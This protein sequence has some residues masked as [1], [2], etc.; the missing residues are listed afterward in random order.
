MEATALRGETSEVFAT[1]E[2]ELEAIEHLRPVR[3]RVDGA[4]KPV[5]TDL[6]QSADGTLVPGAVTVGLE[7]SG[8]GDGPLVRLERAGRS[9]ALS[10]PTTLPAPRVEGDTATYPEVLPDVDL[11]VRAQVDGF[12]QLLVVKSAQAAKSPE[13]AELRVGVESATLSVREGPAGGVEA[14]DNGAGGVVFSAPT[15]MMWD[16]SGPEQA[17]PAG[18]ET[19]G[20]AAT[21][22]TAGASAEDFPAPTESGKLAP[23]GVDVTAGGGELVL[24]PD[25]EVLA[26]A[27]TVYPVLIDPQW[28]SPKATAWTM[29]SKYWAD[30]PQ[31][32]FND[33]SD[34]G[35]GYC[36]WDYC[37]PHDTKRLFYTIPTS[38]FVGKTIL[39]AEFV[40]RETWAASCDPAK[41]NLWRTRAISSST[42][43]N[44]QYTSDFWIDYV[45]TQD[46]AY[47]RVGCA[48]ADAEFNVKDTVSLAASRSWSQVTFGLKAEDETDPNAWKRFSDDAFL[49]VK[50]NRPPSQIRMSQLTMDPGGTCKTA[51]EPARVRILPK[52]RA[53]D[54]TDP[55]GDSVAVQ[56]QVWWATSADGWKARWTS[57]RS[58]S[59]SSGSDFGITLPSSIPEHHR[60]AFR[61]RSWDGGNW[62]PWSSDNG[63]YLVLDT[64]APKEPQITSLEYP[65]STSEDPDDPWIDGVGR[66]GTFTLAGAGSDVTSY[67]Y[68]INGDPTPAN[69][70]TTTD[71][72]PRSIKVL[73]S[74]AGVNFIT[75]KAYDSAGNASGTDTYHFR[76]KTG[77]P[78]RATW[79]F[80]DPAGATEATGSTPPR[81]ATLYGG[82]ALGAEGAVN[83]ALGL[84]GVDDHVRTPLSVVDTSVGFSVAAWAKPATAPGG[85]AVVVAQ[86]GINVPGFELSYAKSADAWAFTRH[87]TDTAGATTVR[88]VQ[89]GS[90]GVQAGQWTHLVGTY[91]ATA[92]E[93]RLFVNGAL[94]ATTP[95]APTAWDA[96]MGI[97]LGAAVRDGAPG[98]FFPGAVDEVQ[99]FDRPIAASEVSELF[100]KQRLD[101]PYR[102]AVAVFPLDETPGEG[103]T[104]VAGHGDVLPAVFHGGPTPGGVGVA[105][106]ALRLDGVDDRGV[107]GAPHINTF[108][109]FAMSVW[110]RLDATKPDHTAVVV[111]QTG[112]HQSGGELF[113]SAYYD[114]WIFN[115]HDAD[116]PDAGSHRAIQ[117][118]GPAPQGGE[119]THLVGVHD[120]VTHTLTLYVNGQRAGTTTLTGNAWY[121]S[122]PLQMGAGSYSGTPGN[123]FPGDIDDLRLYDRPLSSDEVRQ[124]FRQHPVVSGRWKLDQ[125]T[126]TTPPTTPDASTHARAMTLHGDAEITTGSRVDSGA[127]ALTSDTGYAYTSSAPTDT[128]VS[129]TVTAWAQLAGQTPDSAVTVVSQE[130]AHNSAYTIRYVPP[131]T[132]GDPPPLGRWEAT[133]TSADTAG[134]P[135]V[136]VSSPAFFPEEWTHLALVYDGFADQLQLY[137]NGELHQFT[138][139]D[140]D[141]DGAADDPGC[142]DEVAWSSNVPSF[143]ATKSLQLGRDKQAD[144]WSTRTWPGAL[145]DV[146]TF[147]GTLTA[148]QVQKLAEGW[149]GVPT[150][151]PGAD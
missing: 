45:D 68:G 144:T 60:V 75:A 102:T 72:A 54:V 107:A 129:F 59:K 120:M 33:E 51:S 115:Q 139:T 134:A 141:N 57:T 83:T 106:T 140:A 132:T 44:S 32:R 79:Q 9:L 37:M 149:P 74:R 34:A 150:T 62:S 124:L 135:T 36:N 117:T 8:G 142:A 28:Y 89:S 30:S 50:Y 98:R 116:T 4:W 136:T 38:R 66:Y 10:W 53:S 25:R 47:G 148:P 126:D 6:A 2:G 61:A 29:A 123:Y 14:V 42:T 46:I 108:R 55:D 16:S 95:Y 12:S 80:D 69:T 18:Q 137:V 24:T 84:D 71:G 76:V 13:L 41:V 40:V 127:L 35:M 73:P 17:A 15:P 27:D 145:D 87:A 82:A 110:V 65:P 85:D 146:W 151:V 58:T 86:S 93:M 94:A 70:I 103:V 52:V 128:G 43:W 20:S 49:R 147:Q 90:P 100:G 101:G 109:S 31:W 113:Y 48:A 138:C 23:L 133:V 63:C 99:F 78:D 104:E 19:S 3:A 26:G 22:G 97:T 131:S 130:G 96:R 143:N 105:G 77:Q 121:A 21:A 81:T 125:A 118:T 114:K 64:T 39:S 91:D 119:W 1:P 56:F 5:D 88:A 92:H 111:T 7:F 11:R 112:T 67:A 122:G